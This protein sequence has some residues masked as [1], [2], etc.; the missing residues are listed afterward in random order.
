MQATT[1]AM[2]SLSFFLPLVATMSAVTNFSTLNSRSARYFNSSIT[3]SGH[4]TARVVPVPDKRSAY[5]TSSHL[6]FQLSDKPTYQELRPLKVVDRA[7]VSLQ[8]C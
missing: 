4:P 1:T 2:A 6:R 3:N 5:R 7:E 8:L